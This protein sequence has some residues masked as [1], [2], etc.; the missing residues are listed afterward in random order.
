MSPSNDDPSRPGHPNDEEGIRRRKVDHID[1]C[2]R[3]QVEYRL[4]TT[5]LEEVHLMHRSLPEL[6]MGELDLSTP[7]VG[8]TLKAPFCVSGM[9]GG[10]EQARRINR[11]LAAVAQEVGVAFG[12]GSQR[13]MLVDPSLVDTYAVRDVAPDIPLLANIGVV[14]AARMPTRA[15]RALVDAIDAD[16]LCVHMNPAQELIQAGGDR[17][18]R[19]GVD[20]FKRLVDELGLPVIAK[21]TGC[22]VGPET[23]AQ[24]VGAGVEIV[25]VSGAG[26]TTWV[27]VEALR[28]DPARQI[29][30]ED[31]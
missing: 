26:G 22:G 6:S 25:D 18:F 2:T 20:T 21:E 29:I 1:I 11:Q 7:F 30:G 17:D 9:T 3:E 12:V 23:I 27:G 10:A 16:A 24:L 4:K 31:F 14:Q 28:A 19:G 8:R 15:I 13:A 5:L